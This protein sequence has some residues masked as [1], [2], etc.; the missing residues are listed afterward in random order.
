MEGK[1][2]HPRRERALAELATRQHGVVSHE[3][4][5]QLGFGIRLIER[6]IDEHRLQPLHRNVYAVGHLHLGR[7]GWWWAG[8]LAYGPDAVL[9]HRTAAV[10]WGIQR[11]RR[12]PVEVTARGGRQG[13]ERRRGIWIHRCRFGPEDVTGRDGF[14]V[15][16][17]A[18]TLFD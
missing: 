13:V 12:G 14:Q 9:S 6:R 17:V 15:T 8:L 1:L 2:R 10:L 3:Q 5:G 4:L 16:T 18:R 7:R 11:A